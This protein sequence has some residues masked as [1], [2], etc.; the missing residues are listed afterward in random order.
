MLSLSQC[1]FLAQGV[2]WGYVL[3]QLCVKVNPVV[4]TGIYCSSHLSF[5]PELKIDESSEQ[6][7][8][9]AGLRQPPSPTQFKMVSVYRNNVNKKD[10]KEIR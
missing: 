5:L 1:Y 8:G 9:G 3:A 4:C 2:R 10:K 6:N 7:K